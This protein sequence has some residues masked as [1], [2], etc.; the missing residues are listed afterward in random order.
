MCRSPAIADMAEQQIEIQRQQ[1]LWHRRLDT[2]ARV[3][4][5]LQGQMADIDGRVDAVDGR[6]T[7]VEVRLGVLEER[8]QPASFITEL[9]AAEISNRVKGLAQLLSTCDNSK[10]HYQSIF[11]EIYRRFGVSSYKAISQDQYTAVLTFL[12]DWYASIS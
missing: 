6:M 1:H 11:A 10:N 3:I 8:V 9:Q 12:D 7:D 2:A 5:G 4:H